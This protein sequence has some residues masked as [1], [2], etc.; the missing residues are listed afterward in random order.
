MSTPRLVFAVACRG[1]LPQALARVHPSYR[2]PATAIIAQ[3]AFS[4]VVASSGSFASIAVFASVSVVGTYF[5]DA[6]RR[7]GCS[8]S[9]PA[10]RT[11][12]R[13]TGLMSLCTSPQSCS[14][15]GATFCVALLA[16]A[17]PVELMVVA[18]LLVAASAWY[19]VHRALGRARAACSNPPA[20]WQPQLGRRW[21]VARILLQSRAVDNA[22]LQDIPGEDT[23]D[24]ALVR[25]GGSADLARD[26]VLP[27]LSIPTSIRSLAL[28]VLTV[29]AV[30]WALCVAQTLFVP[31]LVG[32]VISLVLSPV[33]EGPAPG[34]PAAASGRGCRAQRCWLP[35]IVG[36]GQQLSAP[37]ADLAEDCRQWHARSGRPWCGRRWLARARWR[38]CRRPRR[39]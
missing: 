33:V 19:Q 36:I 32:I 38:I 22:D 39:N 10:S 31:L 15:A 34:T 5:W 25:P 26:E 7:C 1:F 24:V 27:T 14:A 8:G 21:R 35:S 4:F 9:A 20:D 17:T 23:P 16:Q 37:A 3:T 2:T 29:I 30:T 11:R 6:R 18:A 28:T 13:A 12:A